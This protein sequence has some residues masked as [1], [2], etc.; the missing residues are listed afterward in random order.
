MGIPRNS[1]SSHD[2][3][4][5]LK[6]QKLRFPDLDGLVQDWPKGINPQYAVLKQVHDAEL[7]VLLGD[8]KRYA[9]L[10]ACD[11]AYNAATWWPNASF[12]AMRVMSHLVGW[13]YVW[14]SEIDSP[15]FSDLQTDWDAGEKYRQETI[16]HLTA[17]LGPDGIPGTGVRAE[18]LSAP[19][20]SFN[21]V[22]EATAC[23]LSPGLKQYFLDELLRFVDATGAEQRY[24]LSGRAPTIEEYLPLRMGTSAV[25]A[26]AVLIEYVYA[27][28]PCM[29]LGRVTRSKWLTYICAGKYMMEID[30]GEAL[31]KD[32]DVQRIYHETNFLVS[33][34]NDL[35]SLRRELM[36]PF[37]NLQVAVD[38]LYKLLAG[39]AAELEAA[40]QRAIRR[41]PDR[42]GDLEAFV[43]GAKTMVTG[44]M[45][46]SKYITR[47]G[48]GIS[49]FDG[50]TEITI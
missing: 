33:L 25:A 49:K 2:Y 32:E 18:H 41:Y 30:L 44:N 26:T 42:R 39:S 1:L 36:F 24:E 31:R 4:Q 3:V 29:V 19:L 35:F 37:Y 21:P 17:Y 40:A 6:G 12:D 20:A 28:H 50:T 46:W 45:A 27:N 10:V 47:Y 38:E 43:T 8:S 16:R 14:D 11:C 22:G 7:G 9:A 13:L 34:M 23:R 48:L 15:E 5:T